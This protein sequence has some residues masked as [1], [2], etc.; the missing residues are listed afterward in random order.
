MS[1]TDWTSHA[2]QLGFADEGEFLRAAY[3]KQSITA[4]AK[5][6]SVSAWT[7]QRKL[8]HHGIAIRKRGGPMRVKLEVFDEALAER[9]RVEGATAVAKSLGLTKFTLYN[10]R[11]RWLAEQATTAAAAPVAESPETPETLPECL[12]AQPPRE[13]P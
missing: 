7:V 2:R 13:C 9:M 4:L 5:A 8:A 11:K 3:P 1:N 12:P 10:R 6:L